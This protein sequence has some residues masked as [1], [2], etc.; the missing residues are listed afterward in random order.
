M[1]LDG[2]RKRKCKMAVALRRQD[3]PKAVKKMRAALAKHPRGRLTDIA[4]KLIND[5]PDC[6]KMWRALERRSSQPEDDLWVWAFLRATSD[7]AD[8]PTFHYLSKR[9]RSDLANRISL[10]ANELNRALEDNRLDFQIV[11]I[12]NGQNFPG[13]R[14]YEDFSDSNQAQIDRA[15]EEKLKA[16]DILR[17]VAA[18]ATSAIENEPVAGKSGTNVRAVR[19]VRQMAKRNQLVYGARLNHVIATATNLLYETKY[20]DADIS[21]LVR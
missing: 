15:G 7:A 6:I 13:F 14:V 1:G 11:K 21:A 18:R 9:H 12:S 16:T 4:S 17:Y 8:L 3:L 20:A 19:F 5:T 2:H 10:I